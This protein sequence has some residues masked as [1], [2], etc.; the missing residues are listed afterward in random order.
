[1]ISP[2]NVAFLKRLEFRPAIFAGRFLIGD[3]AVN[4][5]PGTWRC[6]AALAFLLAWALSTAGIA[7]EPAATPQTDEEKAHAAAAGGQ[8]VVSEEITVTSRLREESLQ[9]VPFSIIAPTE[10][11]LRAR[12]VDNLE[13]VAA[14][15]AGLHACRTSARGRARWRCAASPPARSCATSPASRSRSA[16]TWTSR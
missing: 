10:E 3:R 6:S 5:R 16:S 11:V 9:E 12:G 14:N 2:A 15:V 13:G 7:Q 1:M 8:P 4:L